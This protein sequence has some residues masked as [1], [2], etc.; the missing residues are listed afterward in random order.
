[1]RFGKT[2]QLTEVWGMIIP[3]IILQWFI[4]SSWE[5]ISPTGWSL[6]ASSPGTYSI[7][8]CTSEVVENATIKFNWEQGLSGSDNN[9]SQVFF[10]FNTPSTPFL[11]TLF[12]QAGENGSDDPLRIYST[13][14]PITE[15]HHELFDFSS[16]FKLDFTLQ[17][18]SSTSLFTLYAGEMGS[19][20]EVP[21]CGFQFQFTSF[22]C[23]GFS[24]SCTSSQTS[25]FAFTLYSINPSIL[26]ISPLSILSHEVIS[27]S[28]VHIT[29][30]RP[31][32]DILATWRAGTSL[33]SQALVTPYYHRTTICG[34]PPLTDGY[35]QQVRIASPEIDSTLFVVFT[36]PTSAEYHDLVFTEIMADATPSLGFPEDEFIEVVNLSDRIIDISGWSILDGG[37]DSEIMPETDWIGLVNPG[38]AFLICRDIDLWGEYYGHKAKLISWSGLNDQGEVIKLLNPSGTLID[39]VEYERNWWDVEGINHQPGRS[40]YKI[41]PEGCSN[42]INWRLSETASPFYLENS[43]VVTP[44]T[45]LEITPHLRWDNKTELT[46]TPEID[47]HFPPR[48]KLT[49][50]LNWDELVYE[51]GKWF[52]YNIISVDKPITIEIESLKDCFT[53]EMTSD[54]IENW[55]PALPPHKGDVRIC[56]I[57]AVPISGEDEWVEIVNIS[58]RR[59]DLDGVL[60]DSETLHNLI[61]GPGDRVVMSENDFDNWTA[62]ASTS[63]EVIL[64]TENYVIDRVNY[65]KCWHDN[66]QTFSGGNSLEKI[67]EQGA[68][69][70]AENWR[71]GQGIWGNSRG[72]PPVDS[73]MK[74]PSETDV[75]W[76]L[77]EG[78]LVWSSSSAMDSCVLMSENWS[79]NSNWSFYDATLTI[80]ISEFIWDGELEITCFNWKALGLVSEE[81]TWT[82]EPPEESPNFG[83][84]LILNEFLS[85]PNPGFS[86][87]IEI[88]NRCEQIISL[89]GYKLTT[90][91][92]PQGLDWLA[93]SEIE[94]WLPGDGLIVLAECRSW[95]ENLHVSALHVTFKLPS[96]TITREIKLANTGNDH[97]DAQIINSSHKGLSLER[98]RS[99]DDLWVITSEINGGTPG[100]T[101][102]CST[103]ENLVQ[104]TEDDVFLVYPATIS[105]FTNQTWVG[106]TLR[107][108]E[109]LEEISLK[110][111]DLNG[112]VVKSIVTDADERRWVWDIAN[113]NDSYLTI[114]TYIVKLEYLKVDGTSEICRKLMC[115]AP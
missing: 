7:Y 16:L 115:L 65:K 72:I 78:R 13:G 112:C 57:R 4:T 32:F 34:L 22:Q 107:E 14:N 25:S 3:L 2:Y 1:V 19:G 68:S 75:M 53:G 81:K 28:C 79:V 61:L 96:L 63:G 71:S 31:P 113:D 102:S 108:D 38:E 41:I 77:L 89:E 9:H 85:K 5:Q 50:E 84:N 90:T 33:E 52:W 106:F 47:P 58:G 66:P 70:N 87:F 111:F 83:V 101:N 105:N 74:I 93:L 49:T 82:L 30:S 29:F 37:G 92:N 59:V 54:A 40:I 11:D 103:I 69:N 95:V 36:N 15:V 24:A 88:H 48:V 98:V 91:T 67:A 26:I 6:D 35:P 42:S 8:G 39:E 56:E 76:G 73:E 12:I 10:I 62:L 55:V 51:N 43:G 46:I 110:I 64:S 94:W 44:L 99:D 23:M 100:M 86:S 97:S 17:F 60:L 104:S 18:S 80:A 109:E 45:E 21:L 114:G 27:P 20:W